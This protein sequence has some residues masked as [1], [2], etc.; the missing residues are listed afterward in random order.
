MI[1]DRRV[2]ALNNI[3][4]NI[5]TQRAFF[6]LSSILWIRYLMRIYYKTHFFFC[7][8]PLPPP[9]RNIE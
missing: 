2:F 6:F 8:L 4:I 3:I 7:F 9:P 1:I 5:I